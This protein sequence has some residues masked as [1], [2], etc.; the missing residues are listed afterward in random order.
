MNKKIQIT[1][2]YGLALAIY[3]VGYVAMS[4]FS[5]YYLLDIGLSNGEVGMLLAVGALLSVAFQPLVG[6]L[7][8]RNPKISTRKMLLFIS[9]LLVFFGALLIF[10][11]AKGVMLT[12]ILYGITIMLLMLSQPFMNALG[13][14]ALNYGY[15]INI[16]IGK[17]MGSLGYA[18]GSYGFGAVS[19]MFGPQSVPV[20]FSI[21]FFL[22]ILLLVIYPVRKPDSQMVESI[23]QTK[24][25]TDGL[26]N[27]PF[28]LLLRYKRLAVILFGLILVY[29]SHAL[30]NTF[31]L[32][33]VIPKGGDSSTMGTAS[34]I[35]A[36]C[37]LITTVLFSIYMRKFRLNHMIK[38]SGVFFVRKIFFSFLTQNVFSFYLIQ[39]FQMFGWGIMAIGIVYYVNDLVDENDKAQGQAYAGMS[40]T[41]ASVLA[42]FLGGNLIDRLG[43]NVMLII[44]SILALAGTL[45]LF[46]FVKENKK[47]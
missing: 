15:P 9:V 46:I 28:L 2:N 27:N 37:E 41:I 44:G 45:I 11:P 32:Q 26:N 13:M 40:Y 43:V 8:D 17:G 34:A 23:P 7:I 42:T 39:G 25:K 47:K 16:G 10:L 29:F 22:L 12:T 36:I 3:S 24:T 33:I 18:L 31:A 6:G 38:L 5:S 14:D 35:A 21:A 20:T 1:A 4:A 19:V 30:I